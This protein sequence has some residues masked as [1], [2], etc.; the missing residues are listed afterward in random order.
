M[1]LTA[2]KKLV[3]PTTINRLGLVLATILIIF[4]LFTATTAAT[5]RPRPNLCAGVALKAPPSGGCHINCFRADP[6]C[7][8]NGVTYGCGCPEAACNGVRVIKLGSC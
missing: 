5:S 2:S 3:A 6:V 7:G 1:A 8:A 4:S